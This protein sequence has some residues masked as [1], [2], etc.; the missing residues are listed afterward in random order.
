M[1]DSSDY[2]VLRRAQINIPDLYTDNVEGDYHYQSGFNRRA[3]IALVP[4]AI[5]A[6]I[7]ALVPAFAVVSGFSW[8]IGAG[9]AFGLYLLVADR[10]RP[11]R[12]VDGEQLAVASE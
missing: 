11:F 6:V 1:A 2:W 8:F 12:Q 4:A 3:I 5:I 10:S 7:L 9:L